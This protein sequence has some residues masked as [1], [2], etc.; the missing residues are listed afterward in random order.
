MAD[1]II[2][3]MPMHKSYLEPFC[4]SCADLSKEDDRERAKSY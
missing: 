1:L 4:G 3:N 2:K